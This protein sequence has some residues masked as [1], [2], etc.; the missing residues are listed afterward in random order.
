MY[1]ISVTEPAERDIQAVAQYIAGELQNRQ[2]ALRL[3]DNVEEVISSLKEMP[4]RY[5][6]VQ[7]EILSASGIRFCSVQNYLVFYAIREKSK[8]VVIERFL[9][10]KRDWNAI[11]RG[12][13]RCE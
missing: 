1:R 5:P 8:T 4:S 10:G 11:L 3:L 13:D 9:Y 12:N 6:L 2:A 7:D